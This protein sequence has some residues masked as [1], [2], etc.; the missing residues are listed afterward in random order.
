MIVLLPIVLYSG[1]LAINTMFNIPE[2]LN[3]T[4]TQALWISVWAIGFVGSVYDSSRKY[5]V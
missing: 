4:E 1:A 5:N 3:V 2:L